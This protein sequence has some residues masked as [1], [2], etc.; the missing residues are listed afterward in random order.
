MGRPI[1]TLPQAPA[2]FIAECFAIRMSRPGYGVLV[3]RERPREHFPCRPDDRARWNNLHAG[4]PVGFAVNGALVVRFQYEGKTRRL[5]LLRAAWVVA[6]GAYPDG[7][8]KPRDG[9]PHNAALDNL[10][11][12]KAGAKPFAQSAA[13]RASSLIDPGQ[14]QHEAD[15]GPGR[16]SQGHGGAIERAQPAAPAHA[17]V[18]AWAALSR[19]L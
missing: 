19:A 3:G 13:G 10:L 17:S 7:V 14:G 11:L 2:S 8:V 1:Q 15:R 6:A 12:L 4:K 9:D 16:A 5:A 18:G